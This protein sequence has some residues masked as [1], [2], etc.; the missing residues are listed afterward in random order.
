MLPVLVC[1]PVSSMKVTAIYHTVSL[2]EDIL[3]ILFGHL[4]HRLAS[5][6]NFVQ[7]EATKALMLDVALALAI[8]SPPSKIRLSPRIFEDFLL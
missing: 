1:M 3:P 8:I 2:I 7:L 5:D 6:K 4:L